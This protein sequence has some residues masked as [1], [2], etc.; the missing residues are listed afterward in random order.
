MLT[1][2]ERAWSPAVNVENTAVRCGFEL[3]LHPSP[4]LLTRSRAE[5]PFLL[6]LYNASFRTWMNIAVRSDSVAFFLLSFFLFLCFPLYGFEKWRSLCLTKKNPYFVSLCTGFAYT[7]IANANNT[8]GSLWTLTIHRIRITTIQ[9]SHQHQRH[10][11]IPWDTI[12]HSTQHT[13]PTKHS[14]KNFIQAYR[15]AP[16]SGTHRPH[17]RVPSRNG[18]S[19]SPA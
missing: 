16:A 5:Y 13:S 18:A 4:P 1:C 19:R 6:V 12:V 8:L 17:P 15:G 3:I 7:P 9:G 11:S 2:G 14:R 10:T